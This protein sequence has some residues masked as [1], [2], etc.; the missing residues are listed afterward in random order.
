[1][2]ATPPP[3]FVLHILLPFNEDFHR[4]H[5]HPSSTVHTNIGRFTRYPCTDGRNNSRRILFQGPGKTRP[6]HNAPGLVRFFLPSS[7]TTPTWYPEADSVLRRAI[8]SISLLD[9]LRL[10]M[11]SLV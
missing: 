7:G 4:H 10:M 2:R 9:E 1:M 6:T 5:S 8:D 11:C 3:A